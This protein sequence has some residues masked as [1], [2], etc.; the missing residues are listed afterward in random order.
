[1]TTA[2]TELVELVDLGDASEET[3]QFLPLHVFPDS[4]YYWGMTPDLG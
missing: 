4:A 2:P 3:K 1:M